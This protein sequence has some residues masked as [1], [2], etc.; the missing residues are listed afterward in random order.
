MQ[1]QHS[2][3]SDLGLHCLHISRKMDTRLE[4]VKG[5]R[6]LRVYKETRGLSL[7]KYFCSK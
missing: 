1:M 7:S 4:W 2:A 3:A 6:W 5:F